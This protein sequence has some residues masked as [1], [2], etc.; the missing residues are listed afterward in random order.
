MTKDGSADLTGAAGVGG[1]PDGPAVGV[2]EDPVCDVAGFCV[3]FWHKLQNFLQFSLAQ[4]LYWSAVQ[5]LDGYLS[6]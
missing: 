5:I 3:G 2:P 4:P 1:V 6:Q